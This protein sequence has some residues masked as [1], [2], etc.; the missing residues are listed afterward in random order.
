MDF[1]KNVLRLVWPFKGIFGVALV[2]TVAA[3]VVGFV[4]MLA[5]KAF[6]DAVEGWM[7]G[8]SDISMR[9]LA[10][11][12]A[13]LVGS[14]VLADLGSQASYYLSDR[15]Q[16]RVSYRLS[17]D[18]ALHLLRL[19]LG[20]HT[21]RDTA[22]K[23]NVVGQGLSGAQ[24]IVWIAL[25]QAA[26]AVCQVAVFALWTVVIVPVPGVVMIAGSAVTVWYGVWAQRK[27]RGV[28]KEFRDSDR[29]A[30]VYKN[31]VL[32]NIQAV[33]ANAC[34]A[35]VH[36]EILRRNER[37]LGLTETL[38]RRVFGLGSAQ[39]FL[40]HAVAGSVLTLAVWLMVRGDV[41]LGT[42]TL[43][44]GVTNR[45]VGSMQNALQ[46]INMAERFRPDAEK[47]FELLEIQPDVRPP[48]HP[49]PLG[50]MAGSV[51]FEGVS[52]AYPDTA[53]TVQGVSF[54]VPAGKTV[55]VVGP[56]GAG[57]TTLMT[58][59]LRG[60]DPHA[61]R[62]LIDGKDLRELDPTEYLGQV[63]VVSQ[64]MGVFNDTVRGNIA[65]GMPG[66]SQEDVERC[67]RLADAHGF[68]LSL[69]DG[70]ETRVGENGVRLSGGQAQRLVIARALMRDPRL[71]LLD[72]PTSHLDGE[73]EAQIMAEAVDRLKG[74]R[75][76]VIVAHRLS[77]IRRA[78][79]V[80]VIDR[81]RVVQ[82][83]PYAQ[84][85]AEAGA[86]R[87]MVEAQAENAVL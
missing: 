24:E 1:W 21:R 49:L 52:F 45:L 19:S 34:E 73:T 17:G 78:D 33:K 5:Q 83:G 36:G 29:A 72:E 77:T 23:L 53:G 79:Y 35:A 32:R 16:T 67:A 56:S 4:P 11:A 12:V 85:R 55:A 86:F 40:R 57:K 74:T 64:T 44:F 65:F 2:L 80:V 68:I 66:A 46:G 31:D 15:L 60:Y 28:R 70:Y 75:T 63:G 7:R 9:A 39:T 6:F 54:Y 26:P 42:V 41:T 22:E 14:T 10:F 37:L 58:L 48:E 27:L 38:A 51:A 50:R 25:T 87:R 30:D 84:V 69:P 71:L 8:S 47:L 62:I 61:G 20:F 81:G 43:L 82:Q 76:V 3:Q 13:A 18:T 59:L